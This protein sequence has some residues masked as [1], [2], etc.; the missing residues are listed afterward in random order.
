M[1]NNYTCWE[2]DEEL[3]MTFYSLSHTEM[4]MNKNKNQKESF[5]LSI[6]K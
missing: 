1:N 6:K 4:P 5:V 3:E 2:G